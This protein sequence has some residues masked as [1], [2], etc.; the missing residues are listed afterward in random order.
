MP[1]TLQSR[2]RHW[3]WIPF[4]LLIIAVLQ[5]SPLT[6]TLDRAFYDQAQRHPLKVMA[7]AKDSVL[8][9][10]DDKSMAEL[11]QEPLNIH[12]PFPHLTFSAL[13]LTLHKAGAEKIILDFTFVEA[14]PAAEQQLMLGAIAAATPGCFLARPPVGNPVFWDAE[15]QK[16]NPSFFAHA[17]MG[18][19]IFRTDDDGV[20]RHYQVRDS[21]ASLAA[22]DC[23]LPVQA[24]A[25][26]YWIGGLSELK[27]RGLEVYSISSYIAAGLPLLK[28]IEEKAP[29]YDTPSIVKALESLPAIDEK[30]ARTVR[31][32]T[33]FVGANA[34]G[35]FDSKPLPVGER[36]PDGLHV[37]PGLLVHWTAWSN[38]KTGSFIIEHGLLFKGLSCALALML[39]GL[40]GRGHQRLLV[41]ALSA[42][43]SGAG[44]LVGS[45][46]ALSYG[47]FFQPFTFVSSALAALL[48]L[49]GSN[50]LFEQSRKREIQ[51]IFGSYVAPE[52]VK[53]LVNDPAAVRL[54]GERKEASVLFSDLAGFTDLSEKM[55]PERL[56]DVI[57]LYLEQVSEC[58]LQ[59]G[60]Y[61]DKYIGDAAK[62]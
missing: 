38:L 3:R 41:P 50:F 32:R 56:L 7:P 62:A 40:F 8:L 35:T 6:R 57:N 61:I 24:P 42:L 18:D 30:L 15:F 13:I 59:N 60:A 36:N 34:H 9:L 44:L 21:L 5:L 58:L 10:V 1:P 25:L 19:V 29:D 14:S 31:G 17:R 43:G 54:G 26:L 11:G 23:Q 51:A 33:V 20:L 4:A 16:A 47:H 22:P 46:A 12:W 39:V 28:A 55:P 48:C 27:E 52:V 49:T 37:E 45:Y 2:A 53:L